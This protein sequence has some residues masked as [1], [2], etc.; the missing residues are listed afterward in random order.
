MKNERG[1]L[2]H[3]LTS[4]EYKQGL[5]SAKLSVCDQFGSGNLQQPGD[6]F[7]R[8]HFAQVGWPATQHSAVPL[9]WPHLEQRKTGSVEPFEM[10]QQ[11]GDSFTRPQFAHVACP[12]LQHS[13]VPL[14]R[15]QEVHKATGSVAATLSFGWSHP[16]VAARRHAKNSDSMV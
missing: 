4:C 12:G 5:S 10:R 14:I 1:M 16:V 13:A 9:M 3:G 2:S 8:P 7:T 11:L 15:P 6:P